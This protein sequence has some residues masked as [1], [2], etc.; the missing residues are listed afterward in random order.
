[1]IVVA[2]IGI[3]AAIAIPAYLEYAIRSQVAHGIYLAS[4]A[5]VAVA[6]YHQNT[7][8]Y[9]A[10]NVTAGLVAAPSISGKY[11]TQVDVGNE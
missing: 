4:A 3:L 1:M 8:D 9:P 6:E 10:D 2:I 5:K 7:G 11:V